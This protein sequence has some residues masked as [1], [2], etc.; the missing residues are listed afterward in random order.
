M[1]RLINIV[2]MLFALQLLSSC[3]S[4]CGTVT[5]NPFSCAK[6]K[7]PSHANTGSPIITDYFSTSLRSFTCQ[8]ISTCHNNIT[9]T[10]CNNEF[11]NITNIDTEIGLSSGVYTSFS[12]IQVAEQNNN[13]SANVTQG[14]L[15]LTEL[16]TITCEN[17]LMQ[18][19]YDSTALSPL[20]GVAQL[21]SQGTTSCQATFQ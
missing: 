1:N 18:N 5:G 3:D 6:E 2:F 13:I 8:R 16:N 17:T 21:I 9:A 14:N 19:A 11:L 15:C 7:I 10:E 20:E 12:D 4:N